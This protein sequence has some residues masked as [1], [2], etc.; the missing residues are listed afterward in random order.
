MPLDLVL[1]EAGIDDSLVLPM[2]TQAQHRQ[3]KMWIAFTRLARA[4]H[5]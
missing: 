4:S 5:K 1:M 3:P 2:H